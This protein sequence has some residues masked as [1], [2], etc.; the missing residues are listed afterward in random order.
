MTFYNKIKWG[1]G[2]L[3]VFFLIVA[4][5][6]IDRNNFT[7]VKRSV[8]TIYE[9]RLIAKD[10]VFEL[11]LLI[12]EKEIAN[13][14][15]DTAFYTRRNKAVDTNIDELV[16]R[17]QG[18]KLTREEDRV[19][20]NLQDGLEVLREDE[21][22]LPRKSLGNRSAVRD[23]LEDVREDLYKLSKIQVDEGRR[24]L[25]ISKEAINSVEV[26]TQIEIYVLIVLALLIQVI[27]I[28]KPKGGGVEEV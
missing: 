26:F 9:D 8:M 12:Q 5:N 14:V 1:L 4:T 6:L 2:I 27:V 3:L 20:N 10:I 15:A 19:F 28:Y 23:R 7:R 18:T 25:L 17:F 21:S 22:K 16:L 13:A 24:Q 11:S